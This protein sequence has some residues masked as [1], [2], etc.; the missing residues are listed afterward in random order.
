VRPSSLLLAGNQVLGAVLAGRDQLEGTPFGIRLPVAVPTPLVPV[1]WGTAISAPL[2]A[3]PLLLAA[4]D[5]PVRR[6]L[7]AIGLVGQLSEPIT[8]RRDRSPAQTAVIAANLVLT[9]SL[10][11]RR[12][13][14]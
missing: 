11:V 14:R 5:R 10:V 4:G 1:V 12:S 9:A 2:A 6:W 3:V 7:A 13:S 8:W